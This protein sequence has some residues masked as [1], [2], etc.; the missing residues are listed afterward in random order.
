MVNLYG[1]IF[2]ILFVWFFLII[3]KLHF[4]QQTSNSLFSAHIF[5]TVQQLLH[6]ILFEQTFFFIIS[7]LLQTSK[8]NKKKNTISPVLNEVGIIFS[9][10]L[11]PVITTMRN[12]L[13]GVEEFQTELI[14]I[15]H[16]D[17][18]ILLLHCFRE[19][20]TVVLIVPAHQALFLLFCP[21]TNC[22]LLIK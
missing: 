1:I 7:F 19:D 18:G 11:M 4:Q 21:T 8:K 12:S 10:P 13:I 9:C 2:K 6:F 3:I 5:C 15:L 22:N 14:R 16:F 20:G 17:V